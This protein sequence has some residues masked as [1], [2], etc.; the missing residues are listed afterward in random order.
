L[1]SIEPILEAEGL[2]LAVAALVWKMY[3]LI[4]LEECEAAAAAVWVVFPVLMSAI[5]FG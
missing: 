1:L 2:G 3:S 5:Q 4:Y